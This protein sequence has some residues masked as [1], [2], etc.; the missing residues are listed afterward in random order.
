M[1]PGCIA[2]KTLLLLVKN[3]EEVS[4]KSNL[5]V[6]AS[7]PKMGFVGYHK[8]FEVEGWKPMQREGTATKK[9]TIIRWIEKVLNV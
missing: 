7:V 3:Y 5:E 4:K 8:R 2:G 1:S 6:G 9:I